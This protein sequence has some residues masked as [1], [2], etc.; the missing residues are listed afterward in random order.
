MGEEASPAHVTGDLSGG[1]F[2]YRPAPGRGGVFLRPCQ[3]LQAVLRSYGGRGAVLA[4]SL[5]SACYCVWLTAD[6]TQVCAPQRSGGTGP[7]LPLFLFPLLFL[8]TVGAVPGA[9]TADERNSAGTAETGA[10][11]R[12]PLGSRAD[13]AA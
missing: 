4:V 13:R 12:F 6:L 8:A 10:E 3:A 5:E 11:R 9:R 1:C 2:P 7:P